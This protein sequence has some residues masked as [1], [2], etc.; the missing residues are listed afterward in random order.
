M[1]HCIAG[2]RFTVL[3]TALALA[4]CANMSGIESRATMQD[5][6]SLGLTVK[7]AAFTPDAQWWREFGDEQLNQ[8]VAQALQGNPNLKLAQARLARAQSATEA[9]GAARLPHLEGA[10]DVTRQHFS[11]NGLFPPPIGGSTIDNGNLQ[12]N[13]SWEL[14]FFGKNRAALDAALGTA[15]AAQADAEAARVLLASNVARG[16]FQLARL[17]DQ[18]SV[19]RR[20]LAQR[21]ESLRLVQ[22]RVRAG[23]D[24]QLELRQSQGALPEARQQIEALQEQAELAQHALAALIGQGNRPVVR[25]QPSL[26]ALK[27]ISTPAQL[28]A[29]LL[30]QRADIVAARWRVEAA[31]HDVANA[32]A[33]F[34]PN[35]NLMAFVGLS[36]IGLGQL[37]RS[38][39]QQWGVGPAIRLPLFD[40]GGLRANLRGKTA[41]L[42]AAVESY[43]A[44]VLDAIRDAADQIA[45][46]QSVARQQAE[47]RQA[48]D[49]A[50]AAYQI[51]LLRYQA[52]LGT[53]LN[54]LFA[55]TAVLNQRRLGVDLAAHA[56]DTQVALIR[57]LGGGYRADGVVA[58]SNSDSATAMAA[59]R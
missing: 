50:E 16:Y 24:T 28:P 14:D 17:N 30:G 31:G 34:Y 40:G 44:A 41:E 36:S 39:S 25:A 1:T 26:S 33:Q 47:Q 45:S 21:E 53:Y 29:D 57:A 32:K 11:T 48:Q 42:D 23:L 13:G 8:L 22:D 51:A 9:A 37:L 58:Q 10:L 35:I 12:L 55:E 46:S 54:V 2:R 18:L 38:G 6:Q 3:A 49:A 27:T 20:T 59:S 4:G 52:G 7:K 56:L 15:R 43:N 19:A 5:A